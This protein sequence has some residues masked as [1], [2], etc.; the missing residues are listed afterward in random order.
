MTGWICSFLPRHHRY[1]E[2][3]G[4]SAAVL[5]AKPASPIEIYNDLDSGLVTFFR[6]LRDPVQFHEFYRRVQL[7]PY[8]REEYY[9]ARTTWDQTD[10]S[11]EQAVRWFVVARWSFSGTWGRSWGYD[12]A[13][14]TPRGPAHISKWLSV[15]DML[16][17][18]H[19]RLMRVSI[20]HDDWAKILDRYDDPATCFYLDPPYMPDTRKNIAYRHEL[21]ADDHAALVERSLRLTGMVLLSGYRSP[22]YRPLEDAG[23]V[24]QERDVP[25]RSK[26]HRRAVAE[27][28]QECLWINPAAQRHAPQLEFWSGGE[29]H[30]ETSHSSEQSDSALA[31]SGAPKRQ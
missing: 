25:L 11:I 13:E 12:L 3:F 28:R 16:P 14:Y 17:A 10:D 18:F 1:V 27:R 29:D 19:H 2:V 5:F 24:R 9:A 23:W 30:R 21:T 4:G 26:N 22:V 20:E 31:D 6:V 7:V 15:L 8:S